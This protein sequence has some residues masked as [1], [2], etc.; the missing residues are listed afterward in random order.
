MADEMDPANNQPAGYVP[1]K[2]W[3]WDRANG[4]QF[5]NINRPV[6][7]AT[8]EKELPV[9]KHPLQL[10]SLGTPNGQK[11]TILLEELLAAGHEIGRAHV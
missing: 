1:P 5:A 3:T 2:I 9:G 10:Y 6:S 8:H 7:G 4:G 11:V